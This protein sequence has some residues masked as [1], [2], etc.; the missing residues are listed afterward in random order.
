LIKVLVTGAGGTASQSI[1]K[2]LKLANSEKK[3]YNIIVTDVDPLLVGIYRGTKGYLVSRNWTRYVKELIRICRREKVDILVPGSD[4]ELA[5]VSKNRE[6]IERFTAILIASDEVV[7]TCRDKLRTYEFLAKKGFAAPKTFPAEELQRALSELRSPIL[8]KPREGYGSRHQYLIRDKR[9]A[10]Y[11][12]DSIRRDG[13]TPI[14]QEYMRGT[15]FS[16]MAHVAVDRDILGTTCF[17]SVKRFGMSYKTILDGGYEKENRHIRRVASELKATGPLSVQFKRLGRSFCTFEMNARF[18]GAE[19][20][21]AVA[22]FNGPDVLIKN[23]LFGRKRHLRNLQNVIALW[24]AD[25][26]YI[27]TDDYAGLMRSKV[28]GTKGKY[29]KCL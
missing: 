22:G 5:Q 18:T 19:I 13:W 10:E 7:N 16:G 24:F 25:Y 6:Q 9:G 28:T 1:I 17:R 26:M 11:A 23:F 2:C 20:V 27:N 4:V 21:R 8:V 3:E 12:F 14:L 29:P 15:E